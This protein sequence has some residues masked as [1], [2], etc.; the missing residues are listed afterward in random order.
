MQS[1]HYRARILVTILLSIVLSSA[2]FSS[3]YVY[4][5]PYA[6]EIKY[7][8]NFAIQRA[9][10]DLFA[11][12]FE[13]SAGTTTYSSDQMYES[14]QSQNSNV[15][16]EVDTQETQVQVVQPKAPYKAPAPARDCYKYTVPHLDGSSSTL[17]YS[18]SDYNQLVSLG[19]SYSSAKTF[20]EFHLDGVQ[21]YQA[22]YE[23]T[24]SN[25]YLD[26]KASQQREADQSKQKMDAAIGSMQEIEKRGY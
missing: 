9:W 12:D 24:G 16:E 10:D 1:V 19:Y 22:Q 2:I 7:L 11:T 8:V 18:Q 25:I 4:S 6:S 13:S 14:N 17:C 23:Q 21:D 20:Y 3:Y 15:E 5:R 26:A